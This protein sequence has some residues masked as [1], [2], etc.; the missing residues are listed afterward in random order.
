MSN[1]LPP[2]LFKFTGILGSK[3]EAVVL[4]DSGATGNFV[5]ESFVRANGFITQPSSNQVSLADGRTTNSPGMLHEVSIRIG[6]YTDKLNL[7]VTPLHG[8]DIILGMD[9]LRS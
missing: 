5:S 8:Y 4:L 2:V 9:W 3:A 6:T 1:K 7:I